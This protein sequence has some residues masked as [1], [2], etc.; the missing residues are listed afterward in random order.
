MTAILLSLWLASGI[1]W[2]ASFVIY[3]WHRG[4]SGAWGFVWRKVRGKWQ[5][6]P[7]K[8][9]YERRYKRQSGRA[10]VPA[11]LKNACKKMNVYKFKQGRNDEEKSQA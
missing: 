1:I 8:E 9:D 4:D 2:I 7:L 5:W 11:P 10:S 3:T 6:V